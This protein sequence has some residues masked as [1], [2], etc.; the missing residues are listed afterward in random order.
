MHSYPAHYTYLSLESPD[1]EF[2]E[3]F[4]NLCALVRWNW[5]FQGVVVIWEI[6]CGSP[7]GGPSC[8][9][10]FSSSLLTIEE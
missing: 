3:K 6:G 7:S 4:Q 8:I 9:A 10:T 1:L 5:K 2:P